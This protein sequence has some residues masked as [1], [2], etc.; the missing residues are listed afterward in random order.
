MAVARA[1]LQRPK[2]LILDEA[3]SEMDSVIEQIIW[4]RLNRHLKDVTIIAISHRL[5]SLNWV[6]RILVLSNGEIAETG[7]HETLYGA[8]Q[9]YTVLYN[10]KLLVEQI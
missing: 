10:Q 8:N 5:A 7:T 4:E 3:T 1:I 2:V 9:V 6:D